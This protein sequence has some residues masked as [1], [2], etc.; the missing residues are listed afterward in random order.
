LSV[1]VEGFAGVERLR[2]EERRNK[3]EEPIE[4]VSDGG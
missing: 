2:D 4:L 3:G 1:E